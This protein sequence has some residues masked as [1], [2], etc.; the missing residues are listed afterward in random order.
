MLECELS[1]RL[2][3]TMIKLDAFAKRIIKQRICYQEN[4]RL[5]TEDDNSDCSFEFW[6]TV[7]Y[8]DVHPKFNL[9]RSILRSRGEQE[10]LKFKHLPTVSYVIHL[11]MQHPTA[12]GLYFKRL[13][14]DND[15][16]LRMVMGLDK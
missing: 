9:L 8:V 10:I 2:N 16:G 3:K 6:T 5:I 7:N 14:R 11:D 15:Y 12:F 13:V 1:I 4:Y